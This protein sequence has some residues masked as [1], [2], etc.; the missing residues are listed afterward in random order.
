ML[1]NVRQAASVET[2]SEKAPEEYFKFLEVHWQLLFCN[3]SF[4]LEGKHTEKYVSVVDCIED[5]I[6]IE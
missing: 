2:E 4:V 5:F 1:R 6:C 3:E